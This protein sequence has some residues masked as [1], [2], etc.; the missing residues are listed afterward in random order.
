MNAS[1]H[2]PALTA[3]AV[4]F[5]LS[6]ATTAGADVI[7]Q[8]NERVTSFGGPQVQRT[9]AMVHIAM[10]DAAN[11]AE[12]RYTPYVGNLPAPP[13]GAS[14][15]AAAAA[16]AHRVLSLVFPSPVGQFDAT[17]VASLASIPDGTAKTDG[18]AYGIV[19][20]NAVVAARASDNIVPPGPLF[21]DG[22]EPGEYRLTTPGPPQ[23]VNTGAR[24]WVPFA[25]LSASQFRPNGP[26]ALDSVAYARDLEETKRLGGAIS[27]GR[28]AD[29]EELARWH[30]EQAQ[31]Q[32]NRIAR[33][34][35]ANDGRGLLAHARLF[36][37]LNIA[38]ADS[39]TAVFDAKYTYRFWRPSTAIRNADIDG[40]PRTDL[41][42][43]WSPFLTTPPHPEYPAAHGS[44]Q[45][46]A[47]RVMT[48]YFGPH[49][50]F[51]TT[52]P[53]VPNV[54]RRYA[55]FDAFADEGFI[56]RIYGG[57]HFRSSLEEGARQGKKVG[58]WVI[59]HYLLPLD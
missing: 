15:E 46:A 45:G 1:K 8:W 25:L 7:T 47:A 58:N 12:P 50:A 2:R 29:Q 13:A 9:L 17:L 20:A 21:A 42:P 32:F 37:L 51:E 19:V 36:A 56:A 57:M 31:F 28:N 40:N 23:P 48:S 55:S 54:T 14:A 35:T 41:D 6:I 34:E 38:L 16:A 18:I 49:H 4:I 53:A 33:A 27:A 44:V 11:A 43:A 5:S 10:F 26:T 22:T 59:D 30:T 24:S 3:A 39:V 52:A